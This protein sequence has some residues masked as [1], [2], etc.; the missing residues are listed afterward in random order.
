M[1]PHT[2]SNI[3][4]YNNAIVT[5][6]EDLP[7]LLSLDNKETLYYSYYDASLPSTTTTSLVYYYALSTT[8]TIYSILTPSLSSYNSSPKLED[9]YSSYYNS[10][11][12]G[13]STPSR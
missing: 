6:M 5:L 8:T 13:E 7:L 12:L 11:K 4:T 3:I 2:L 1:S 10:P 9:T